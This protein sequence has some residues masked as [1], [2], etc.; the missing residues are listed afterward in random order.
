M[1]TL[2]RNAGTALAGVLLAGGGLSVALPA[3][4]AHAESLGA[5]RAPVCSA[6]AA[7]RGWICYLR[8][9]DAYYCYYDC[10]PTFTA[11]NKGDKPASSIKVLRPKGQPLQQ[12]T[13]P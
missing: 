5:A 1:R 10:Y 6:Q 7:A 8:Y 4:T 12:I 13:R 2:I 3:A 11:R 9:C